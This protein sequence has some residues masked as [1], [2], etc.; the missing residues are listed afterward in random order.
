VLGN[1]QHEADVMILDLERIQNWR[2]VTA[3]ELDIDNGTNNL[4][5]RQA[6][7]K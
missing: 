4:R 2:Q 7:I 5:E 6:K 1:L 3:R